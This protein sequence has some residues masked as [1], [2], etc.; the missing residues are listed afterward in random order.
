M[1]AKYVTAETDTSND[2]NSFWDLILGAPDNPFLPEP[3]ATLAQ[4]TGG[5]SNTVDPHHFNSIAK[6]DALFF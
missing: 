6:T 4:S 1:E 3:F 5:I 2:P